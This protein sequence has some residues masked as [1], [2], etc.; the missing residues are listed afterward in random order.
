MK[1][2]KAKLKDSRGRPLTQSLFLEVGYNTEFAVYT[3]K[4]EDYEYQG[5]TY[6]SLKQLYLAY[7]DVIEYDFANKY[8]LGWQHWQ[9]ICRNKMFTKHVEEWREELEL[10]MRA[11]AFKDI[12]DLSSGDKGFQA[13]KWIADKGWDK[14]TAGRP[15][16]ADIEKETKMQARIDEEYNADVVRLAD[17]R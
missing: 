14:R 1:V 2:D 11:Q 3:L 5:K 7:E 8:L 10:K 17:A 15:S 13:A 9:R 16:N 12:V 4:D 6:Y